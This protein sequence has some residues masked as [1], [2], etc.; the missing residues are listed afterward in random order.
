MVPKCW[1]FCATSYSKL[2]QPNHFDESNIIQSAKRPKGL[3]SGAVAWGAPKAAAFPP[4]GGSASL[5]E[6]E[7]AGP[8]TALVGSTKIQ[9]H[10]FYTP[11]DVHD[12]RIYIYTYVFTCVCVYAHVLSYLHVKHISDDK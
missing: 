7:A 10:V 5:A 6:A 1:N 8:Q 4:S 11:G 2:R 3:S 9:A 12:M